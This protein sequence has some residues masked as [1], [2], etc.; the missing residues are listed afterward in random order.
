MPWWDIIGGLLLAMALSKFYNTNL[1]L[2]VA[3][4]ATIFCLLPDLDLF[5]WLKK[6]NWKIDKWAH[7]HRDTLHFPVI[8]LLS[9]YLLVLFFVNSFYALLFFLSSMLHFLHDSIGIGWGVKWLFPFSKKNYKFFTR[10]HLGEKR[11]IIAFWTPEELKKE[12]EARGE[13][14]WFKKY[15]IFI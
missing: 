8:Y 15:Y 11:R 7:E 12:V 13:N 5:I 6:H 1:T 4:T 14:G 9:G 2:S 3:L 10:Q